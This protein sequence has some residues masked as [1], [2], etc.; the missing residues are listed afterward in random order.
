MQRREY[1]IRLVVNAG[2]EEDLIAW[3][4]EHGYKDLFGRLDDI[5]LEL[6]EEYVAS[7]KLDVV[8]DTKDLEVE[9]ASTD[10]LDDFESDYKVKKKK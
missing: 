7:R 10:R 6:L 4:A 5:P 3:L 2:L 1:L 9:I 8:E